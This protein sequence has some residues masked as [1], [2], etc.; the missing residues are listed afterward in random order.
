[1]LFNLSTLDV[2]FFPSDTL[3][4]KTKKKKKKKKENIEKCRLKFGTKRVKGHGIIFWG[5]SAEM[6]RQL[7]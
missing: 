5:V 4:T 6:G 2:N 3:L 1:M 7:Y